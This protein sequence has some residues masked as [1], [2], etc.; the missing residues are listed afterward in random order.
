MSYAAQRQTCSHYPW[1]VWLMWHIF[2][3]HTWWQSE[4]WVWECVFHCDRKKKGTKIEMYGEWCTNFY[5]SSENGMHDFALFLTTE[6]YS[7]VEV[8]LVYLCLSVCPT[9]GASRMS[10]W[11]FIP[12]HLLWGWIISPGKQSWACRL[13]CSLFFSP[14]VC[15]LYSGLQVCIR[16]YGLYSSPLFPNLS[17]YVEM[18]YRWDI[19]VLRE[20]GKKCSRCLPTVFCPPHAARSWDLQFFFMLDMR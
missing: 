4:M 10:L 19:L 17:K 9:F 16:S 1:R 18:T 15:F 12:S 13:L 6:A 14:L 11:F 2:F 7:M 3:P 20:A 8:Q 5:F